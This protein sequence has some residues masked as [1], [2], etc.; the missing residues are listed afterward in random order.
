MTKTAL[1]LALVFSAP[2]LLTQAP[3]AYADNSVTVT[4]VRS[5]D[6]DTLRAVFYENSDFSGDQLRY[7]GGSDC[8]STTTDNDFSMSVVPDGWNDKASAIRDYHGCD[9]KIYFDGGFK[10]THTGYLNYGSA[11]KPV[12]SGFNDEMSSFRVS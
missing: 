10:N 5:G 11:G 7:Y 1:A 12:P 8:S 6:G 3:A 4:T 9:V 2:L